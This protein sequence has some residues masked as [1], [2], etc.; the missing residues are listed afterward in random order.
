VKLEHFVRTSGRRSVSVFANLV[1]GRPGRPTEHFRLTT[2][3]SKPARPTGI[4][5]GYVPDPLAAAIK[6]P[7]KVNTKLASPL[8]GT[9]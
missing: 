2:L 8:S 3:A 6:G 1:G 4:D 9:N 5:P 7:I